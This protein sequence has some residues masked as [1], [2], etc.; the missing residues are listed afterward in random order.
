MF[1]GEFSLMDLLVIWDTIFS[2]S[3]QDFALVNY[4]FVSMLVLLRVQCKYICFQHFII[5]ILKYSTLF[6]IFAVL[7]SDNTNCLNLLMRYPHV[8][9]MT[10]VEYALHIFDPKVI[11]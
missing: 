3:P 9:V 10:V 11:F 2:K 8:D 1:G 7:K 5:I 4:I 6:F